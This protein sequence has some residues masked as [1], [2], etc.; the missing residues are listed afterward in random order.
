MIICQ[1]LMEYDTTSDTKTLEKYD[2]NSILLS[3]IYVFQIG[4]TITCHIYNGIMSANS[5]QLLV[6]KSTNNVTEQ[7]Y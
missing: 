4:F 3:F 7:M 5:E 2:T 6:L 1:I